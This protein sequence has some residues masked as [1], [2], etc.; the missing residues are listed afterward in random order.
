MVCC[1]DLILLNI[2]EADDLKL[3]TNINFEKVLQCLSDLIIRTCKDMNFLS[4]EPSVTEKFMKNR[5]Q[6]STGFCKL[7]FVIANFQDFYDY[8]G[9]QPYK[10]IF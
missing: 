3:V 9:L 7:P 10:C 1:Y 5:Q 4:G 8:V 6:R 2:C